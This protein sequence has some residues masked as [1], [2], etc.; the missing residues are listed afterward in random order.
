MPKAKTA[1]ASRKVVDR[2]SLELR[3]ILSFADVA[4]AAHLLMNNLGIMLG[5]WI[6]LMPMMMITQSTASS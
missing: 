3:S 5:W 4:L 1:T 6:F 2:H